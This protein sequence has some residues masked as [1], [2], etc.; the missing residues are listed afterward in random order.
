MNSFYFIKLS[1]YTNDTIY[2][3]F[4]AILLYVKYFDAV[5]TY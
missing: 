1:T 4:S 3:I 5:F 2:S